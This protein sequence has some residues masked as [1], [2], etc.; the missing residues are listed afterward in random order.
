MINIG[1][2]VNFAGTEWVVLDKN[3]DAV[4]CFAKHNLCNK[5]FDCMSNNYEHSDIRNYLN[6]NAL[7]LIISDIG[8]DSLFDVEID[9]TSEDGLDDY[10]CVVDKI[11]LL[12][13][14]M[15]RQYSRIIELCRICN[16]FMLATPWSTT[17]RNDSRYICH[18][19]NGGQIF[20]DSR[21]AIFAVHPFC[22]IKK[23]ALER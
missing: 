8:E 15:Y 19:T 21:N 5:T 6:E 13:T 22:V 17:H 23:S 14:N 3:D 4:L 9:L 12:T 11:G 10:G 20:S 1:D 7:P 16:S 2:F 18:V